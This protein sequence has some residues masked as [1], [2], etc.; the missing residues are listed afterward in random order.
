MIE[1]LSPVGDF[2]CLKAAVQ[3]GADSVYFGADTFSARAFASNFSIKELERAIQYAKVRGVKTHLTLNTLVTDDEFNQAIDIA[4]KA[5]EFGIDAIIVQDLGLATKLI[6]TFPQLPI[7]AST[8]MTVHNLNGALELQKLGF[9]RIVLSRELSVNEIS[10]ICK[11]TDIEIETFIHGALCISYSGQCL[12]SSMIGGRSGN[13][14]KCAGPCR[15]PFELLENNKSIDSGYLLSTRDLCG[16]E[17]IPK[18]ISAGVSCFKIEGRMKSPE[19]VAIVTNI[20][21]KYIDLALSE[22]EYIIDAN[23]KKQLLQV[24]NRGMSSS[25]HLDN[26]G[27]KNLIFKEKPN[28]MGLFLGKVQKYNNKRGYITVKINEPLSIGDTISL[29]KEQGVYTI[30]ELMNTNMQNIKTTEIGQ[31]VIIG[32]MKG[33]IKLGNNIFKMSSKTLNSL[34]RLSYSKESKKIALNCKISIKK[35]QPINIKISSANTLD[36]YKNLKINYTSDIIPLPA[37][38]KP[39][40]K[41]LITSQFSKTASTPY[42]FKNI[43]IDLDDGLFIP[44][45]SILN[46][47]RRTVLSMTQNYI[48]NSIKR[49]IPSYFNIENMK[50]DKQLNMSHNNIKSTKISLLLNKL[51]LDFDYSKIQDVNAL[52]I[53][54]KYFYQKDFANVLKL[55][56]SKF[57]IYM[58]MPTII[59]SNYC[60][61][62]YNTLEDTISKYN[63]KGFV[64]SNIC[65]IKILNDLF[66]NTEKKLPIIANY[67]FNIYNA[68]TIKELKELGISRY[69]ISPELNRTIINN[70]CNSHEL[71]NELIVYG[72]IPLI[73]MNYCLLGETDKCYPTCSQ[74]CTYK[75]S[76]YLKDRLNMKF[77][78]IPNNIQTITTI[79]NSKTTS[80]YPKE[81]NIDYARID[82]LDENIDEINEIINRVN[83]NQRFEGTNYTNVNLNRDI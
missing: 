33:N 14:G 13:R 47:L 60:N 35:D 36:L 58:Y 7:H 63:I 11:N 10:Y 19:Y 77:K 72:N 17:F 2:E 39:L 71:S 4:T 73:T 44:K 62:F 23:D 67:T 81:F 42:I 57:D 37:K 16:L 30:S 38:N 41:D 31:T 25:G 48:V 66:T 55:L 26:D 20:Y 52:Y 61:L 50:Y 59:K 68:H 27:N 5:Y 82:I 46:D 49:P 70:L 15:L 9:K 28:N 43:N 64:I 80:I 24:F 8:Q 29:E 76:Y 74:K 40:T 69:T 12:F 34:A 22:N 32:R 65:N 56:N 1:L 3:N 21:R 83:N 51:N 75:N 79:Y 53:P 78:V 45:L 54:F 6:K 18:L